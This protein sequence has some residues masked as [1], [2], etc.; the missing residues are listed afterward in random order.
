MANRCARRSTSYRRLG[1]RPLVQRCRA[2]QDCHVERQST[3]ACAQLGFQATDSG[4]TLQPRERQE[5]QREQARD[6]G[7]SGNL[8]VLEATR[9]VQRTPDDN[10]SFELRVNEKFE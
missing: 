1:A 6:G 4:T 5:W 10:V 9:T 2:G 3:R 7:A 8:P